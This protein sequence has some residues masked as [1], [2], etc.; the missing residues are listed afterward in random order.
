MSG[1]CPRYWFGKDGKPGGVGGSGPEGSPGGPEFG[2]VSTGDGGTARLGG[3]G[4]V[5]RCDRACGF[6]E[7]APPTPSG[8]AESS[9]RWLG[10]APSD[11]PPTPGCAPGKPLVCIKEPF[12]FREVDTPLVPTGV[13][14]TGAMFAAGVDC[15]GVA[16]DAPAPGQVG[17]GAAC[18]VCLPTGVRV[19]PQ[20]V[21]GD[22][23]WQPPSATPENT[24]KPHLSQGLDSIAFLLHP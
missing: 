22:G 17:C 20:V 10:L 2:G 9:G 3:T 7:G 16:V 5:K 12:V 18:I 13:P 6:M 19:G 1:V 14:V 23:L 4:C 24:T 11:A 8:L 21:Q 15:V